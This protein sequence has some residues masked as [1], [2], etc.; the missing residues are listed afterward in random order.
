[1]RY[2]NS[3]L[4][5]NINTISAAAREFA[6]VSSTMVRGLVGPMGWENIIHQYVPDSVYRRLLQWAER[7]GIQRYGDTKQQ[8]S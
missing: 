6:E 4:Y 5:P 2:I 1:M 3:D 8:A 7:R